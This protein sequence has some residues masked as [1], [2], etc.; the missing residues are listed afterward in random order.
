MVVVCG[1]LGRDCK[2]EDR[3]LEAARRVDSGQDSLS[4]ELPD[5]WNTDEDGLS[6]SQFWNEAVGV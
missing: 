2:V 4:D 1:L 5:S 6:L 3:L